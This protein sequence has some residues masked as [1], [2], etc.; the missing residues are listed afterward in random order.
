LRLGKKNG[1][2]TVLNPAPA[3]VGGLPKELYQY[4]DILCPN[5]TE[6]EILTGIEVKSVSDAK[7]AAKILQKK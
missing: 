2:I 6:T 7:E 1:A 4:V 3:P 5:E